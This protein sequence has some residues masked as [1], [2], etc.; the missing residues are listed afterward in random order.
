LKAGIGTDQFSLIKNDHQQDTMPQHPGDI[1]FDLQQQCI[2]VYCRVG[3]N[4]DLF[5]QLV[6][7]FFGHK[8]IIRVE[9]YVNKIELVLRWK[10]KFW[11]SWR[12]Y[13]TS[14]QKVGLA[15]GAVWTLWRRLK[16]LPLPRNETLSSAPSQSPHYLRYRFIIKFIFQCLNVYVFKN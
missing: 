14:G 1:H 9:K 7:M 11:S 4:T 13:F 6:I 5:F 8:L 10:C 16:S 15:P 12:T 2:M 3:Q